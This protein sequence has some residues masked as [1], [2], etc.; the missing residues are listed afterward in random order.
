MVVLYI[1]DKDIF[2]DKHLNA[3]AGE[4]PEWSGG[5]NDIFCKY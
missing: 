5:P 4:L 1:W 3:L 2:Q